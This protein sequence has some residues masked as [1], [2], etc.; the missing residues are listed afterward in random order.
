MTRGIS[1]TAK[2]MAMAITTITAAEIIDVDDYE[3]R[4]RGGNAPEFQPETL[5]QRLRNII[6]KFSDE[7]PTEPTFTPSFERV[8]TQLLE[9][10]SNVAAIADAFRI[11]VSE[12]P[13]K[14]PFYAALLARLY[15]PRPEKDGSA[16]QN[17]DATAASE[18]PQPLGRR[19]L[20]EFWKGFQGLIDK[21]AWQDLRQCIGFLAHIAVLNLV[22][23]ESLVALLKSFAAV[24]DEPVVSYT[25]GSN[26]AF[27][28]GEGILR[29]W[30]ILQ[31]S[32]VS[33]IETMITSI[34]GFAEITMSDRYLV[35]PFIHLHVKDA[36]P[37]SPA[38]IELLD[39]L[40]IAL[41]D[42]TTSGQTSVPI[43]RNTA[44]AVTTE[45]P[46]FE[47]PSFLVPPEIIEMDT[48]GEGVAQNKQEELPAYL[49]RLFD[50]SITPD[51]ENASGYLMRSI[52][53]QLA[54]IFEINRRE[55]ARI[56]MELPKWFEPG[57]FK[58]AKDPS[59]PDEPMETTGP[60]WQ[61]ENTLIESILTMMLRL[62]ASQH[63]TIY[64][65]AVITELCKLS[66]Q[67]VG[68]AVG[69]CIRKLYS[70]LGNGL[71]VDVSRRFVEW[72]STHMSNFGFAWVWK[73]WVGD[74]PLTT[75]HP[76]RLFMQ[77]AVEMQIRLSYY[78]RVAKALPEQFKES[79]VGVIPSEQPGATYE[80]DDPTHPHH[81]V[82]QNILNLLRDR[83][84]A[85]L[86][87]V[88]LDGFRN[89]LQE[90]GDPRPEA[91]VRAATLQALLQVGSRSFSHLLNAIERYLPVLRSL[92]APGSEARAEILRAT[93]AFWARSTQMVN[94][95]VDKLM[96]YQIV[97]PADVV[98]FA[99]SEEQ[100]PQG[101]I[102]RWELVKA[103]LDKAHGRLLVAQRK[104]ASLRK[105]ED[106]ARARK[107]A[108][109]ASA[110][111]VDAA[112]NVDA[113]LVA[114]T[115]AVGEEV[116]KAMK[117]CETLAR[118]ERNSLSRALGCFVAALTSPQAPRAILQA[119]SWETRDGWGAPEWGTWQT[120]CWY[121]HFCRA[122]APQLKANA[123]SLATIAFETLLPS[124]SDPVAAF[125]RRIW[126]LAVEGGEP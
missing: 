51:P 62:P 43:I 122:Y 80:Y 107:I 95:V 44:E 105:D 33:D 16:E 36:L 2:A 53:L 30:P 59:K 66:P 15:A 39:S 114:K 42:L 64:H 8:T 13:F 113:N 25:R 78:D 75:A 98:Q 111:D 27:C 49:I 52:I 118:D 85:E 58:V 9:N 73:E 92:V 89:T 34:A 26:A 91:V 112:D 23:A 38:A 79:G 93:G 121:R 84:K 7:Q 108:G 76:K 125:I 77:R 103:A 97:E 99:F 41:R 81:E 11:A 20:E 19:V 37:A 110:M 4:R 83:T 68:P 106:D 63:K 70:E 32:Y 82:A 74:L 87:I 102:Q 48:L 50:N 1:S 10:A 18:T 109:E 6:V 124:E 119:S 94:I 28:V 14:S 123:H 55:A 120:W 100:T 40:V 71:D 46:P 21:L 65:V 17:G 96:Q 126:S 117:A 115:E 69:K 67:T 57:T 54:N 24:L 47:L 3:D 61:L 88:E 12:L 72:F 104:A 29:A 116:S 101:Q 31:E 86:V 35:Q 45:L 5:E 60:E 22:S 56:L 90:S